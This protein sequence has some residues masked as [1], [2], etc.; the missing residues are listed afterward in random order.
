LRIFA[1]CSIA[2]PSYDRSSDQFAVPK[3]PDRLVIL[4]ESN[5]AK[6]IARTPV[7]P[8]T[9]LEWRNTNH[10]FEDLQLVAPGSPVTVTGGLPER[11]NIQYA[12]PGLFPL[13]GVQAVIG[14]TFSESELRENNPV[15]VS[16]GY[17]QRHF[18][19]NTASIGGKIV[20]NGAVH[21]LAGVL[22]PD[23]H[24]FDE[25]ADIWLPIK[26]PDS[27]SHDY[28]FR[29]WLIAVGRLHS[30]VTLQTAQSEMDLIAAQVAQQH[31]DSN[32]DWGVRV[33]S[34]QQA[35]FGYWKPI[36]SM[37]FGTVLL[38]L[39]IGCANI[40]N[41]LLGRLPARTGELAIR[42]SLGASRVRLTLQ[43]LHEGVLLG[44]VGGILG[45][46]LTVWGARLFITLAPPDFPL[47]HG[48]AINR[49]VLGFCLAI[50]L[51]SGVVF[52]LAPAVLGS[53][54]QAAGRSAASTRS[55]G[56]R[57]QRRMSSVFVGAQ[58]AISLVLLSGAALMIVSM[59]NLFRVDPGFRSERVLTMQ[60]FLTGPKYIENV[61]QGVHIKEPVAVFYRQL[62]RQIEAAPGTQSV[63][64][65]SWL[66]EGGY[67]TGRRERGFRIVGTDLDRTSE[68]ET[69]LFNIVS[70]GYFRTMQIPLL[71][72]RYIDESDNESTHWV[73]VVNSTFVRS[74]WLGENP[75]GKQV[76]S[77][78]G[79]DEKPREIVGVVGDI[80]QNTLDQLPLPEIFTSLFQQPTVN[81]AHGYQNRVHMNLVLKTQADAESA[82][83]A[84]RKIAASLD[85]NQP[86][87]AVRT[88]SEVVSASLAYRTLYTRWLELFAAIAL[89]LAGIGVYSVTS[90]S[91]SERTKEIGI[92]IATGSSRR[93]ILGLFFRQ[94][95]L[96]VVCGALCGIFG[97]QFASRLLRSLLFGVTPNDTLL[98]IAI[99]LLFT[100]IAAAAVFIPA[101]HA[102]RMDLNAV[103]R[104]E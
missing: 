83:T 100:T 11:V 13:L 76:L 53:R 20:V 22:P 84:V 79:V 63:G 16:F 61:H 72:G 18:G 96:P 41:L 70:P 90:Q 45:L 34:I 21:I 65:V 98:T 94:A 32:K 28:S 82:V 56:A 86:V 77:D 81:F 31:P 97:A 47:L 95:A 78:G 7:A 89:F 69:A 15:L 87:Y 59:F 46:L 17:W 4:W 66:P 2:R 92:R 64:L 19:G 23:F 71:A 26:I 25:K 60:I 67:N 103:L 73:A 35:Q 52:S 5:K 54:M 24:L 36:L 6:G 57:A 38:V 74:H 33:E 75:I 99:L 8:A 102:L 42:A 12:T 1:T 9:F 3:N 104:Y 40:A 37:L 43:L 55:T 51:L 80:R 91:V 29:S 14:H 101:T 50:S 85:G 48:I 68:T 27:G 39:L 62:V 30:G 44:S 10:S 93:A 49:F 58:I 88:M